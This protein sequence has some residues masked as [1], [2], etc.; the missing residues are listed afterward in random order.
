MFEDGETRMS[1][2]SSWRAAAYQAQK[3]GRALIEIVRD[4]NGW[5]VGETHIRGV[6]FDRFFVDSSNR[7]WFVE[8]KSAGSIERWVSR[9]P[10]FILKKLESQLVV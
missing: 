5:R 7:A 6:W 3:T 9:G 2:F 10:D 1:Y 8:A 4:G